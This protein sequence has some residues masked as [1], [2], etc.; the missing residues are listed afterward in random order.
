M[1]EFCSVELQSP[2]KPVEH[3]QLGLSCF[4][5]QTHPLGDSTALSALWL[6]HSDPVPLSASGLQ[7]VSYGT[8]LLPSA[9]PASLCGV[10]SPPL[11]K[12]AVEPFLEESA[13]DYLHC[14]HP[15]FLSPPF[16]A[17]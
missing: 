15:L 5:T 2:R 11:R 3:T 6:P 17:K 1:G 14:S 10:W 8:G 13:S 16:P 7:P 9:E 4:C 12:A